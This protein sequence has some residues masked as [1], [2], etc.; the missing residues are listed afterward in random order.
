MPIPPHLVEILRKHKAAQEV[1]RVLAGDKW[2]DHSFVFAGLDG[3][4]IDPK[5]DY[6]EWRLLLELVGI[7]VDRFKRLGPHLGRHTAASV[8]ILLGV[9]IEVVQEILGHSDVRTTRGYVHVASDLARAATQC[10]G[11]ALLGTSSTPTGTPLRPRGTRK[12][13]ARARLNR[14]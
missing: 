1:E 8:L 7:A 4:P 13:L 6:Q 9:P 11:A 14:P 10:M 2:P 12:R 3:Q 5:H